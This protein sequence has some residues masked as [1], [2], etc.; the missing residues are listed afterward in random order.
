MRREGHYAQTVS[1]PY[2]RGTVYSM[3]PDDFRRRVIEFVHSRSTDIRGEYT[4]CPDGQV[5][6]YS[7]CFAAMTLHYLD[8]LGDLDT[9]KRFAWVDYI[10][11]WQDP[12]T[13]RF[14][15]PEIV[16]EELTSLKH[17]WDHVTMHL[18][19]HALPALHILGGRPAHPLRFVYRFLDVETLRAW[20]DQRDWHDAWLEGNNL[21]FVGQFLVYLRD[22]ECRDE[23]QSAL[24]AY[25]N[26]LDTKQDPA[27]GLWGTNGYCDAYT[28]IYGGYHQLLVYYFCE[29]PVP[30]AE[31]IMDTTL[32]L[33]H[34]DGSFTRYGG[35][36]ACEDLDAVDILAN[37]YSL[38]G[39][40][41]RAVRR[42]LQRALNSVLSQ[43]MPDGGFVYRRGMPF[44]HMGIVRTHVSADTSNLFATWFRVHT[45]ALACQVL[46]DHSLAEIN[47][48]FNDTCSMG[49]HN[50]RPLPEPQSDPWY[51][52]LPMS[53]RYSAGRFRNVGMAIHRR[54][55]VRLRQLLPLSGDSTG[56]GQH[57]A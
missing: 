22:F 2:R 8:A 57:S 27:S 30:H 46:L 1:Q 17:D 21:L 11:Q 23:A 18:T 14:L 12:E 47:W 3:N 10:R 32:R 7:S 4:M 5:T 40:R 26:W 42:A 31:R 45:I 38:T 24:D 25:F 19:A 41:P 29:R 33:Q 51:D 16:P 48:R 15:G 53:R 9:E 56:G 13:G 55:K 49:W 28:A 52:Y 35:G 6:L 39:H 34:P 37:M 50:S 43:Q 54:V 44:S 36:G 20:L